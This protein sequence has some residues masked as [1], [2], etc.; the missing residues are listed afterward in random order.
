MERSER[1]RTVLR[2]ENVRLKREL[3]LWKMK[4]QVAESGRH[5]EAHAAE[6]AS[7]QSHRSA[8]GEQAV[9]AHAQVRK[10]GDEEG[11][12]RDAESRASS[13]LFV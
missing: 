2:M 13:G 3:D 1:E 5:M 4:A 9:V 7:D 6:D 11:D 10:V 12:G 8:E